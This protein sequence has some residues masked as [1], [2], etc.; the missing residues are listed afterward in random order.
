MGVVMLAVACTSPNKRTI[1]EL[2]LLLDTLQLLYAPDTRVELWDVSVELEESSVLLRGNLASKEVYK[3]V[4]QKVDSRF[5]EVKNELL[6][7]PE[8]GN[9]QLVNGLVNNSVIHLRK[10][11]SSKTELVTQAL[12]GVP[13]RILK[14]EGAKSL[15]QL[16][17]GYLGWVNTKEVYALDREGLNAFR[18]AEKLVFIE[19]YG[20]AFSE[21]DVGSMPMTD[22]VIGN[23]LCKVTEEPGFIQVKYPDGRLGWV[24]SS[25]VVPADEIFYK[26]PVKENLVKT[27][28]KYH[29]IPYLWGGTSSKNIDC[30]GLVSNVY[31]MNGIQLPRDA[32]Q[33]T[34]TGRELTTEFE[35]KGLEAGDLLFFGRK[36]TADKKE[37][38][39]HVAMYIGDGE[40]IHSAGYRE[41]V[42][43]NSM[44][45]TRENFIETY[46]DIF[47]RAV[48]ILGE[49]Y[50]GFSPISEN[51]Y[52]KE[53]ISTTE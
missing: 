9:G 35:S 52:Y 13:I 22:L 28:L 19:Q 37:R 15:I 51:A 46:P 30:S 14:A 32:D 17:D 48:R 29:G 23:I 6:L 50:E 3:A 49:V 27:A 16:P 2:N 12:L 26:I 38:T 33:Q 36:A 42:S 7:L 18:E 41:R 43:I 47:V 31:F 1:S 11:P 53:I 39:S 21:P 20:M 25:E 40:F 24:K 8:E 10:E 4:I 44:D 5:P 45:S 34:R